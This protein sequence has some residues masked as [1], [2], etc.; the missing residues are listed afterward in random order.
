MRIVV[1]RIAADSPNG[2]ISTTQA[3]EM[4]GFYFRPT[5]GDFEPNPLRKDEPMYMQIVGNIIES[6]K[7]SVTSVYQNG[8]AERTTDGIRIT[9]EGRA[10]LRSKGFEF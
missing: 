3:K 10:Y 4:A 8:Y 7:N 1:L 6:H 9:A 5:P 2:E